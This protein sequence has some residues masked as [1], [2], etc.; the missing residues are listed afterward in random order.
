MQKTQKKCLPS[1][2]V[3]TELFWIVKQKPASGGFLLIQKIE[4]R[5]ELEH[6]TC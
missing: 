2:R 3:S 1:N 6:H 4:L 5:L